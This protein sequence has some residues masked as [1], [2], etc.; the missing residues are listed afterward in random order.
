LRPEE[1]EERGIGRGA[2]KKG[3]SRE[4][5]GPIGGGGGVN[6]RGGLLPAKNSRGPSEKGEGKKTVG[7]SVERVWGRVSRG[8]SRAQKIHGKKIVDKLKG[9][10]KE[11]KG[12]LWEAV[13]STE[14]LEKERAGVGREV[15]KKL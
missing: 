6:A 12:G 10:S 15:E 4:K 5:R 3:I 14:G 13:A 7:S 9:E 1:S 11:A 2:H 8:G